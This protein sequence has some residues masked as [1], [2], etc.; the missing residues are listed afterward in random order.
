M[1]PAE[2][3]ELADRM[4]GSATHALRAALPARRDEAQA[5][6]TSIENRHVAIMKQ[7]E[8]VRTGGPMRLDRVKNEAAA[9][10]ERR[11]RLMRNKVAD[12][13]MLARQEGLFDG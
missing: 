11:V 9:S 12:L 4:L 5:L 3:R 1:T 2:V 7:L 10:A 6:H 8:L 13:W